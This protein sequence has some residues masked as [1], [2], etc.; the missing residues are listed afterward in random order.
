MIAQPAHSIHDLVHEAA[1]LSLVT[2]SPTTS[3]IRD[4]L[5]RMALS[6]DTL[7]GQ[8]LFYAL[9]AFS[10]LRRSGPNQDAL[11]FK[12]AALNTLSATVDRAIEEPIEAVHH[13]ATCMLLCV[14]EVGDFVHAKLSRH[15]LCLCLIA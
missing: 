12:I 13:V 1:Y 10:S 9:V 8:A 11:K 5:L 15:N 14:F 6:N 2:F 7:S 4:V 3:Q